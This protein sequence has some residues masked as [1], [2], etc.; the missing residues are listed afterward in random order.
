MRRTAW[1][2]WIAGLP[3]IIVAF[4]IQAADFERGLAAYN[5]GDYETAFKEWQPLAEQG[6]AN[7]QFNLGIMYDNGWGV[8]QDPQ[9]AANW[10]LKAAQQ[11]YVQAQFNLGVAYSFGEG[12]PH[13]DCEAVKW[14]RRAAEQGNADAQHGLGLQ[15]ALGKGVEQDFLMSYIWLNLA[16]TQGQEQALEFQT[17]VEKLITP[18]QLEVAQ[19]LI[20]QYYQHYV[21]PFQRPLSLLTLDPTASLN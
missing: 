8:A 17:I 7:A 2:R 21:V 18:S 16:A 11:G 9:Y 3:L 1:I 12:V 13:D 5:S 10:Y 19:Q 6:N 15:Y 20:S 4:V 14:Y